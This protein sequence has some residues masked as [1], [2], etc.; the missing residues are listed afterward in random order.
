MQRTSSLLLKRERS[1]I[2]RRL[3]WGNQ[4]G[5]C[6][7]RISA[8]SVREKTALPA[9][10]LR[11]R[12]QQSSGESSSRAHRSRTSSKL[13]SLKPASL[14]APTPDAPEILARA[15]HPL[16]EVVVKSLVSEYEAKL[17]LK[18]EA[19][20]RAQADIEGFEEQSKSHL[21]QGAALREYVQKQTEENLEL[22]Q[23][24]G[25]QASE[26]KGKAPKNAAVP[27]KAGARLSTQAGAALNLS[28]EANLV[29]PLVAQLR[30]ENS[31]LS[32]ELGTVNKS[33]VRLKHDNE[34]RM[35]EL[36]EKT[37]ALNEKQKVLDLAMSTVDSMRVNMESIAHELVLERDK[38]KKLKKRVAAEP[39]DDAKAGSET[40]RSD[41]SSRSEIAEDVRS[42][43]EGAAEAAGATKDSE[44]ALKL[45]VL[46]AE[47][48]TLEE[49]LESKKADWEH[50]IKV[51][52]SRSEA[53]IDEWR[54]KL[55][56]KESMWQAKMEAKELEWAAKYEAL[57]EEQ[58]RNRMAQ[59]DQE[60][61]WKMG[62]D[63]WKRILEAKDQMW[64]AKVEMKDV[65]YRARLQRNSAD[66][67]EKLE[68]KN[69]A[70]A[71]EAN[72]LK[73]KLRE[74]DSK[75]Q[76]TQQSD[77]ESA[78]KSRDEEWRAELASKEVFWMAKLEE[79]KRS[80][81]AQLREQGAAQNAAES[82]AK[83]EAKLEETRKSSR[84]RLSQVEEDWRVKCEA[85]Q[86]ALQLKQFEW[87]E[88]SEVQD[89]KGK[90]RV[91]CRVRPL[92]STDHGN[93]ECVEC[94][95]T[96]SQLTLRKGGTANNGASSWRKIKE[97][98]EDTK[99]F[100]FDKMFS[101]A[102]SQEKIYAD[103]QPLV[104]CVL[105]GFNVCV[106]AYG[107]TGSGKTYTMTGPK[108]GGAF[109]ETSGVNIRALDD[110][111]CIAG[112][113][114]ASYTYDFEVQMVEIYNEQL[115]DLLTTQQT[116]LEIK[117]D[118]RRGWGTPDA[119]RIKV[120]SVQDVVEC[121]REGDKSRSTGSTS[122]NERSSRSHCVVTVQGRVS[123]A[124]LMVRRIPQCSPGGRTQVT[125]KMLSTGSKVFGC[126][127]LVDLAGSERV[128]RSEVTGD[129]LK[130][131]Q[132]INKS[133][134]SLGDVITAFANN[135]THIP[136]R[137][138]KLTHLLQ[139]VPLNHH[140]RCKRF[141]GAAGL[142]HTWLKRS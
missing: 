78:L 64:E 31:A 63:E 54:N 68:S 27:M 55:D 14:G 75:L 138:S 81:A 53:Q 5:C 62:E 46:A 93:V 91:Y 57:K 23:L 71:K 49:D 82:E 22:V 72:D 52:E 43:M 135:Q 127:H 123:T 35:R 38:Y 130:E 80:L 108:I 117:K 111:F 19:W 8:E 125:G 58:W 118:A 76:S 96:E 79:Q 142:R 132:H 74:M 7:Y 137:N 90:I 92:L 83:L 99:T 124:D 98:I 84:A 10:M 50:K 39:R 13:H 6:V 88:Q 26:L 114:A 56:S 16:M 51:T 30:I 48:A 67:M 32:K 4:K 89:L 128:N 42:R 40:A 139:V 141:T 110:L 101:S 109:C 33:N 37:D 107:Q 45:K 44:W 12:E 29:D 47:K 105:D 25:Q 94:S 126:I 103:M 77:A 61:S 1:W 28:K 18:Q 70:M 34:A 17:A 95:E 20:E 97:S 15:E 100:T 24:L 87:D 106:L 112:E 140:T 102:A 120:C 129:R 115:R 119:R 66:W 69:A 116:V 134:A 113:R 41:T 9:H 133:L 136:Y 85:L 73:A 3:K 36:E 2:E 122:M 60:W 86:G 121:M 104:R 59:K 21:E 131:A 11:Q 65:E